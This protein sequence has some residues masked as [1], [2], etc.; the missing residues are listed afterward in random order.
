M[1]GGR[2]LK[3]RISLWSGAVF[4]VLYAAACGLVLAIDARNHRGQLEVLLYSQSEALASYYASAHRLDFPELDA[5]ETRAPVP[6]WLRVVRRGKVLAATP[7]FPRLPA[8][9][10][11]GI[12]EGVV[13][14]REAGD[15]APLAIVRHDVWNEPGT[16]VEAAASYSGLQRRRRDLLFAMGIAG[17]LLIPLAALGGRLM[18]VQA[19]QPVDRLVSSI[20]TLDSDRLDQRL[21]APGAVAEI[22]LLT[23]EFNRLLDRLEESVEAMQRFTAD[24]SH[25]LRTPLSIL[26]TGLEV[27]LR[28]D[29]SAEEYRELLRENLVEIGRVQRIVE[30]LLTLARSQR[31]EGREVAARTVDFA[32]VV[33]TAVEAIRPLAGERGVELAAAIEPE[34]LVHGDEDR[35]RLMV[36]NLLDNAVKFTPQGRKV[37]VRLESR[38]ESARFE[39]HDEGPGVAPADRSHVFDRFFRG[40]GPH[41]SGA[42]AGGLGL[43]V[44][45][46]VAELHGGE[47]R[48]VDGDGPG[49]TFEVVLPRLSLPALPESS[50]SPA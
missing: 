41:S 16:A 3:G 27:T 23:R 11:A 8:A 39:V 44:V 37:E 26:R 49:A 18:A 12:A 20:R 7:G 46:W 40:K 25:E 45:R 9:A 24:A 36:L 30:G 5:L 15:A 29:R 14:L 35:L 22:S 1:T 28:K 50:A 38:R 32:S 33:G 47:V 10:T 17:L 2:S 31:A 48:L 4:F 19:L 6:V 13:T 34:V 42:A 43:S 21:E